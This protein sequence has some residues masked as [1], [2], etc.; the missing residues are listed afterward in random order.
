MKKQHA[1]MIHP[2]LRMTKVGLGE[3]VM[4][5]LELK[6]RLQVEVGPS[7]IRQMN[8]MRVPY[9]KSEWHTQEINVKAKTKVV[10]G[11][12]KTNPIMSF[13]LYYYYLFLYFY[14]LYGGRQLHVIHAPSSICRHITT[15]PCH[16]L[17]F[18]LFSLFLMAKFINRVN[19]YLIVK[20]KITSV[21][22]NKK[23]R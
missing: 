6:R 15:R 18:F 3:N 5:V 13:P 10:V 21:L 4:L 11:K 7:G 23:I 8:K 1:C 17:P 22:F 14:I 16:S 20:V 19:K 2:C 9:K 12:I